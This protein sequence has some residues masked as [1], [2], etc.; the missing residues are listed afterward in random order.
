MSGVGGVKMSIF[1][2]TYLLNVPL[3]VKI[4]K[5]LYENYAQRKSVKVRE[6]KTARKFKHIV[7]HNLSIQIH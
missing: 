7:Y 1:S 6:N 5:I 3:F 4:F 2:V